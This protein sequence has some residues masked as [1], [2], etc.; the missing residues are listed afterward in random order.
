MWQLSGL[1]RVPV[2]VNLSAIQFKQK[3]LVAE[4]EAVLAETGLDAE[5][6]EFD[7]TESMIMEE[8]AELMR[9]LDGLRVLGVRLAIDDFGMGYSS[10]SH[11]KRFPIHKLKIDRS[12]VRDIVDDPD[13]RAITAAII[14]MARNMGITSS[15]EGVETQAQL[16]FLRSRGCDEMQGFIASPPLRADGGGGLPRDAPRRARVVRRQRAAQRVTAIAAAA[17]AAPA[18]NVA[19]GPT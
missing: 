8:T 5:W 14:D 10:L 12:F 11:L 4:V 13:D 3:N 15:A 18:M 2:A 6:L 1:P 17:S 9:T 7:L 16:E 19:C